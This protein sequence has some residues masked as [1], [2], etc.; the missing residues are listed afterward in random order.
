VRYLLLLYDEDTASPSTEPP[1]P[2]VAQAVMNEY[3]AYTNA[4]REAGVYLGGE[5]LQPVTS[6]T[7][8]RVRDGERMTTDGP[9]AETKEALGGYY[10]LECRDLDEALDWA[11]RCPAAKVGTVEVR[12]IWELPPEYAPSETAAASSAG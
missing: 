3:F 7:S 9:F 12:P 5:A 11:A 6:A 8:V 4:V 1:D 10:L 2:E